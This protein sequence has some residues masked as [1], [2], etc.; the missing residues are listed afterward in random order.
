MKRILSLALGLALLTLAFSSAVMAR[1]N[2]TGE[3]MFPM[4]HEPDVASDASNVSA[5]ED[6]MFLFAASGAGAYGAP[7]TTERGYNFDNGGAAVD[8]GFYG[9]DATAQ[10]D[11]YWH[12]ASTGIS[13]GSGTDMSAATPFGGGANA[14]A[15]WCGSENNCGWV[16]PTGYGN[17][18]I[19]Y[20]VM[21]N[22][23]SST[24]DVEFYRASD[25][26][27]D[28]WDYMSVYVEVD[29]VLEEVYKDQTSGTVA[30]Q[31]E[32]FSIAAA[33]FG[34]TTL[35]DVIIRF[36]SDGAW[37]D[38]DGLFPTNVGAVWVDNLRLY[39][40]GVLAGE[41]DFESGTLPGWVTLDT[42]ISAGDYA[43]L[44]SNLF[45]ED[46]CLLNITNAW[47]F[48]D[49]NTSNPMYPLPVVAYGP[50]YVENWI[51][52]PLLEVDQYG[53]PIT[54]TPETT[55]WLDYWL[56][57]D[58]PMDPLVFYSWD[59]AAMI[60]GVPC[61]QLWNND[62]YVY[63]GDYKQWFPSSRDVT[64]N[65]AASAA[66]G[67]ITG[68][69]ARLGVL[70]MCGYWCDSNGSG[71]DHP[72][73]PFFDN[74]GMHLQVGSAIDWNY[75][76]VDI[77]QDAFPEPSGIVRMDGANDILDDGSGTPVRGDSCRI[78]MNMD[79]IGGLG[80]SYNADA[81]EDRPNL[82]MYYRIVDGPHAGAT[83]AVTADQDNA[84]GAYS[85]F[86]G[87][88]ELTPGDGEP[89]NIMQCD[90]AVFMA[91]TPPQPNKYCF[92]FND[93]YYEPGDVI[94]YF[95]HAQAA[96]G[97]EESFPT[98]AMSSDPALRGFFDIRALP[99]TGS[100]ILF[101]EDDEGTFYGYWRIAF[102]YN[103]YENFD[104]FRVRGSSSGLNNDLGYMASLDDIAQYDVI[105]WESG[106]LPA[107]TIEEADETLLSN[108]ID[109][110]TQPAYLWVLGDKVAGHLGQGNMFL[111]GV[112]GALLDS[113]DAYY[114]DYT[115][116]LVP[117]VFGVH[118]LLSYLGGDPTFWVYGGCPVPWDFNVI[119]PTGSLT[120]VSH[121]WEEDGGS[122]VKAGV[123]NNDPDGNGSDVNSLGFTTK[124]LFNPFSYYHV[125]DSGYGLSDGVDYHYKFVGDV[126]FNLFSHSPDS[127]PNDAPD[128]IAYTRLD[129]NFPNPFNPKT[130]IRFSLAA[131]GDVTLAVYDITG[132]V[133]KTLVDGPM[134]AGADKEIIWDGM[135]DNGKRA[136]SGVYFYKLTADGNTFTD[137]MVMLK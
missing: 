13:A 27:G 12:I 67:N 72:P 114:N 101:T 23:G 79:L 106:N 97:T 42:P 44:Y 36:L 74:V 32:T 47:A 125:R 121:E 45:S 134:T 50:P 95:F 18:W 31:Q 59:V 41:E 112:L 33:D 69:A 73:G 137:K 92:D 53:D 24:V 77:F 88:A 3:R 78:E 29:G 6:T 87:T 25:Y 129:G 82:Y 80:T 93:N 81:G 43:A 110:A 61:L 133:V 70:D 56:Y 123:L 1:P 64:G 26:E 38:Q 49:L 37:S 89:W 11:T 100:T 136:A 128:A 17:N 75:R 107:F 118:P 76:S 115:G 90:S 10:A 105:I 116:I 111:A 30:C 91:G 21:A 52:S 94:H 109:Q 117:M 20:V 54:I 130:S 66:G 96:N 16:Y 102:A 14:Y 4:L 63:Y 60:D 62:N 85:P 39:A 57:I 84:D 98:W 46:I 5:R 2:V 7:G 35:G 86:T 83:G 108:W 120:Q 104:R 127:A 48:F 119:T 126:L 40:D 132:R 9:V 71:N 8:C 51:V 99:N 135:M 65:V 19:Q 34:G 55:I 22:A 122:G 15:V 124:A 131:D 68:V 113:P 58:L 103:G 28:V